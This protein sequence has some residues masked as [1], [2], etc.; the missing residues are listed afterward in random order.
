MPAGRHGALLAGQVVEA[1]EDLPARAVGAVGAVHR[2]GPHRRLVLVAQGTAPPHS[3]VAGGRTMLR[4][5]GAV[6]GGMPLGG[7]GRK[8]GLQIIFLRHDDLPRTHRAP[9]PP[10][11]GRHRR[12]PA[13]PP[14]AAPPDLFRGRFHR[15]K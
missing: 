1:G 14:L 12:L 4:G 2:P 13:V 5:E 6:A 10:H 15:A 7:N 11:P 8:T 3:A 9:R